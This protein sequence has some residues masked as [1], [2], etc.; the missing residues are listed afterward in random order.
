MIICSSC[1]TPN[2]FKHKCCGWWKGKRCQCVKC[3]PKEEPAE[4][5]KFDFAGT[6]TPLR[7]NKKP[8]HA[9]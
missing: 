8:G 5:A 2:G 7:P 9:E 3:H 6:N 1:E 4:Q